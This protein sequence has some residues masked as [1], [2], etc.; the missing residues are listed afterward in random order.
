MFVPLFVQATEKVA[1]PS[2]RPAM[3]SLDLK[4]AL[5]KI[6]S[7]RFVTMY[8]AFGD[9]S[10]VSMFVDYPDGTITIKNTNDTTAIIDGL[11]RVG[12]VQVTSVAI[13]AASSSSYC[14]TK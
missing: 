6:G 9:K 4:S 1:S 5:A 10:D 3:A 7:G 8:L 14:F 2:C 12:T 11:C 13:G